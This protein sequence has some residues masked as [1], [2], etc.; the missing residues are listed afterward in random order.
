VVLLSVYSV[1]SI[2][3]PIATMATIFVDV[4]HTCSDIAWRFTQVHIHKVVMLIAFICFA[5]Y[6]VSLTQFI[7]NLP[8]KC[9]LC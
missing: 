8:F 1:L 7:R 6:E 9:K 2:L 5:I 4:Q 3:R